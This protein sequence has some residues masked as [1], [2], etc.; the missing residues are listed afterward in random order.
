VALQ[1]VK[2]KKQK[3]HFSI[4]PDSTL[5][6]MIEHQFCVKKKICVENKNAGSNGMKDFFLL[7]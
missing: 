2:L 5:S 1:E 3:S 4:N 6:S 7:Y